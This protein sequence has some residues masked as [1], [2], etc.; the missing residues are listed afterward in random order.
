M[1]RDS[2]LVVSDNIHTIHR[3]K[4]LHIKLDM[5]KARYFCFLP[6]S[7]YSSVLIQISVSIIK[8]AKKSVI[9]AFFFFTN[10]E[11]QWVQL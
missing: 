9:L 2:Q 11:E 3:D 1:E 6:L 8:H 5:E 10:E 7:H 4:F